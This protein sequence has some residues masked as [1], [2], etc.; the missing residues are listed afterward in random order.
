M[1]LKLYLLGVVL[2]CIIVGKVHS[3][4]YPNVSED[5][6]QNLVLQEVEQIFGQAQI[7]DITPYYNAD[8]T[9]EVYCFTLFRG[10]G[11]PPEVNTLISDLKKATD[12]KIEL[13]NQYSKTETLEAKNQITICFGMK[14]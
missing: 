3:S 5:L 8:G 2:F 7:F 10:T 11:T 13:R 1:R 4:E 12:E 9:P 14:R 6:V